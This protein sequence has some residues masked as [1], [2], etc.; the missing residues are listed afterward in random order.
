[1]KNSDFYITPYGRKRKQEPKGLA[2][3]LLDFFFGL[4]IVTL[5]A[6]VIALLQGR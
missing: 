6:C 1:M 2:L 4:A 5:I 3:F